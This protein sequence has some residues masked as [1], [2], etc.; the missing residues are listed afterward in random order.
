MIA[1]EG[2]KLGASIGLNVEN[3]QST[4]SPFLDNQWSP[5][6]KSAVHSF[7]FIGPQKAAEKESI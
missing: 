3:L 5:F 2:L 7:I 6:S 4:Y 1:R